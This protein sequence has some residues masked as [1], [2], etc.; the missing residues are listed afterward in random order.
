MEIN[1]TVLK[2][3]GSGFENFVRDEFTTLVEVNDRIFSTSV[4]LKY[5]FTPI[6]LGKGDEAALKKIKEEDPFDKVA[7]R[8]REITLDTFATDESASVQA[9]LY[10]M[11]SQILEEHGKLSLVSY[12]LPNKHYIPVDM[13]YI[14]IDNLTPL[15]AMFFYKFFHA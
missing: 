13:S 7:A 6:S 5:D 1:E 9:T 3:T 15:S 4:D 12:K 11:A 14:K 8:A 10:K 2:T